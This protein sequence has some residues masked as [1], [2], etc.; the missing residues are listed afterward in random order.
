MVKPFPVVS[1]AKIQLM[2]DSDPLGECHFWIQPSQIIGYD[3]QEARVLAEARYEEGRADEEFNETPDTLIT[4]YLCKCL[5]KREGFIKKNE[6]VPKLLRLSFFDYIDA[7]AFMASELHSSY[8]VSILGA[9]HY[10]R[11]NFF[12][13]ELASAVLKRLCEVFR[14]CH[15]KYSENL[16]REFILELFHFG[17]PWEGPPR[18]VENLNEIDMLLL[19]NIKG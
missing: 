12:Q 10:H 15:G 9:T 14:R 1:L 16:I 2:E 6:E 18:Y 3:R 8:A 17:Y 13:P 19:I 11:D 5:D 7:V 4:D